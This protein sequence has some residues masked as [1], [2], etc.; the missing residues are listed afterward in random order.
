MLA[1]WS[2]AT[3]AALGDVESTGSHLAEP[4][5]VPTQ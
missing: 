4:A 5:S 3:V 2:P 1:G